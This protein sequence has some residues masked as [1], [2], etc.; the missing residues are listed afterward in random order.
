MH[1]CSWLWERQWSGALV[2]FV[3]KMYN[4]IGPKIRWAESLMGRSNRWFLS[5]RMGVI[6]PT[7]C[8][9]DFL[10]RPNCFLMIFD[11][12]FAEFSVFILVIHIDMHYS[13][14]FSYM[15]YW[16]ILIHI[17]FIHCV[18]TYICIRKNWSNSSMTELRRSQ[19]ALT[20]LF[21][22]PRECLHCILRHLFIHT[23]VCPF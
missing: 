10:L 19:T 15:F 9:T 8:N 17:L 7:K 18:P 13:D 22:M 1:T 16:C 23:Y 12:Q 3:S 6:H 5:W 14:T 11:R 4:W 20:N 2:N 21:W